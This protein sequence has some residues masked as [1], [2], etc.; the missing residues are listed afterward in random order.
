MLYCWV[1][2]NGARQSG[3]VNKNKE[4]VKAYESFKADQ[5]L[6]GT[7]GAIVR[8][9]TAARDG[10]DWYFYVENDEVKMYAHNKNLPDS[11]KDWDK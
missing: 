1:D 2:A 10:D 6:I 8:N 7:S 4:N 5:Y 11:L 3:D 9:K